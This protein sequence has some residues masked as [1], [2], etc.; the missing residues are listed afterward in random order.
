[1]RRRLGYELQTTGGL[2]RWFADHCDAAGI[3]RITSEIAVS[4]AMIPKDRSSRYRW[5]R[6][7]AVRGF[8]A[9]LHA[10]DPSHQIPPADLLPARYRRPTPYVLS[11]QELAA[12]RAATATLRPGVKVATYRTL[13]GLMQATGIRPCEA[14]R[15]DD[16]DVEPATGVMTVHGKGGK[17]RL[18]PWHPSTVAALAD[19]AS[20]RDQPSLA[21][22]PELLRQLHRHTIDHP[23]RRT[24]IRAAGHR[25]RPGRRR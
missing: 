16:G 19:Y 14:F 23:M 5:T 22:R 6:L 17:Q 24:C 21:H 11:E 7:H 15:M 1:M 9:Y 20:L 18:I 13:I 3:A 12:L 25:G 8:A 4:W 10:I 2:V